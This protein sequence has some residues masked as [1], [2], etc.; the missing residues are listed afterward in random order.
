MALETLSSYAKKSSAFARFLEEAHRNPACAGL[1][2]RDYL[3]LPLSF[4]LSLSVCVS[5]RVCI[6]I[7]GFFEVFTY[8][9]CR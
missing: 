2:I 5:P 4:S 7:C 6:G 1:D 3:V 8:S 9:L